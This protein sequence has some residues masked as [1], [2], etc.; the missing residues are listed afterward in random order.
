MTTV[1]FI[2]LLFIL[3]G[4]TYVDSNCECVRHSMATIPNPGGVQLA[5][6]DAVS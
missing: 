6:S 4:C 1:M 5:V 2:L 3:S